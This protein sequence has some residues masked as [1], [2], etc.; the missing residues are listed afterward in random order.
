MATSPARLCNRPGCR[1]LVR[2]SQ[3]SVCGPRPKRIERRESANARGYTSSWH[4]LARVHKACNPLCAL[5]EAEGRT[6]VATIS[7]H[8]TA[9]ASG[10]AVLVGADELLAVCDECHQRVE[11]LGADWRKVIR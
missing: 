6:T 2:Q 7:H 5:C 11:G 1:G 3:C 9:I 4:R 10:G 8:L